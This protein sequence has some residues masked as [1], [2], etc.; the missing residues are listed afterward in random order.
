MVRKISFQS[1]LQRDES[2]S[3]AKSLPAAA[4]VRAAVQ[5][6]EGKSLLE[7]WVVCEIEEVFIN[8]CPVATLA[9]SSPLEASLKLSFN[10]ELL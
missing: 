1:C 8:F 2:F 6:G 9:P 5:S 3:A 4:C 7:C 10:K